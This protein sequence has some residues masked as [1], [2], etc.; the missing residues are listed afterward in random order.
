MGEVKIDYDNKSKIEIDE[1]EA[2]RL[3]R[4]DL[5]YTKVFQKKMGF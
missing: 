5:H 2:G 3:L 4:G 1:E